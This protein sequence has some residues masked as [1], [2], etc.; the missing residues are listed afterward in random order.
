MVQDHSGGNLIHRFCFSR[1]HN[2]T[3]NHLSGVQITLVLSVHCFRSIIT[4]SCSALSDYC[5]GTLWEMYGVALESFWDK[6]HCNIMKGFDGLQELSLF[7]GGL[8]WVCSVILSITLIGYIS[9]HRPMKPLQLELPFLLPAIHTKVKGCISS[10][11]TFNN[12]LLLKS[13]TCSNIS[14]CCNAFLCHS[15]WSERNQKCDRGLLLLTVK[16]YP[17]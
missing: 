9:F 13:E 3:G 12:I 10:D 11:R 2:Y 1:K 7:E 14:V 16:Q 6:S 4:W 5:R 17:V 15:R 8:F